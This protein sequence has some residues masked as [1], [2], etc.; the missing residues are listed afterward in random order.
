MTYPTPTASGCTARAGLGM[1]RRSPWHTS[2]AA[3]PTRRRSVKKAFLGGGAV[4][5]GSSAEVVQA[6]CQPR[7]AKMAGILGRLAWAWS[8]CAWPLQHCLNGHNALRATVSTEL[9][10][11]KVLRLV[12]VLLLWV[13]HLSSDHAASCG[14]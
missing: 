1:P 2:C 3:S 4:V 5:P 7:V 9:M 8:S 10:A 6:D 13:L 11:G 12:G 14:F